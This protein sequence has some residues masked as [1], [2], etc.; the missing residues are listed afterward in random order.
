VLFVITLFLVH[1]KRAGVIVSVAST[2][3]MVG[4]A[5]A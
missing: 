5:G 2:H 1:Q 3:G 4:F